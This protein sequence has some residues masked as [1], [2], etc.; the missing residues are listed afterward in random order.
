MKAPIGAAAGAALRVMFPPQ[1]MG[2]GAR[3]EVEGTLC[4]TCWADTP[5]IDGLVCDACGVPLPGEGG[6]EL[7][8]DCLQSPRPWQRGRAAMIYAGQARHLVL[9]LKHADR[10]DLAPALAGWM[11]RAAAPILTEGMIVAPVPLAWARMMR[12]RANQ[13][14]V[15]AGALCRTGIGRAA[16]LRAMPDLL[17]RTRNTGTQDGLSHD[18]RFL[19]MAGAVAV[20]PRRL[21]GLAGQPVLLVDDVM[22]SGATLAACTAACLAAGSGAVSVVTLARV[23]KTG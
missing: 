13:S 2:C 6:H 21:A 16:G 8:D 19:N 15:L 18:A 9:A 1:C 5:F 11:A 17:M 14:A 12:R 10:L 20:R 23:A 4:P 22:T 3:V 7:C